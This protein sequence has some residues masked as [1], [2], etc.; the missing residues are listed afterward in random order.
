[1]LLAK[2]I[3]LS[4]SGDLKM[5]QSENRDYSDHIV[6]MTCFKSAI[7]YSSYH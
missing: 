6:Q 4:G 3:N 5:V 1:M 2:P 7:P